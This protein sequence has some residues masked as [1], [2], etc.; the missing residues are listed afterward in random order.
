MIFIAV[1]NCTP[2][3][4]CNIDL[5]KSFHFL[6]FAVKLTVT[7]PELAM[8]KHLSGCWTDLQFQ[9]LCNKTFQNFWDDE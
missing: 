7:T 6:F 4:I 8:D 3:I 1:I 9:F 2:Y 5:L